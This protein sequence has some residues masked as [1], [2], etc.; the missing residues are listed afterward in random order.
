M[1][2]KT[3]ESSRFQHP[4]LGS[5][6]HIAVFQVKNPCGKVF[7]SSTDFSIT[8]F[9]VRS[10]SPW[11]IPLWF[12]CHEGTDRRS[13]CVAKFC[14]ALSTCQSQCHKGHARSAS[15]NEG[16][17]FPFWI[18][19]Q[20]NKL[21]KLTVNFCSVRTGLSK[22]WLIVSSSIW[23]ICC[24]GMWMS[25]SWRAACS[26]VQLIRPSPFLSKQAARP[27]SGIVT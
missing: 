6:A 16:H 5:A 2:N 22:S 13:A 24:S 3:R 1:N 10:D 25:A 8:D 11:R 7:S 17:F 12:L 19:V 18:L 26:S 4:S 14:F 21:Q 27:D 9:S 23:Q 20:D 15:R